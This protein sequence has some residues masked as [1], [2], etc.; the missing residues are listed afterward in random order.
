[1]SGEKTQAK[2]F[3]VFDLPVVVSGHRCMRKRCLDVAAVVAQ[4]RLC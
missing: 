3:A 4:R 1:M 2:F